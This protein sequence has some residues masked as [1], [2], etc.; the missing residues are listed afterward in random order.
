MNSINFSKPRYIILYLSIA[1]FC[2]PISYC[3][4]QNDFIYA[5]D[6]IDPNVQYIIINYSV[7]TNSSLCF[8]LNNDGI[9]DYCFWVVYNYYMNYDQSY[10]RMISLNNNSILIMDTIKKDPKKL[11]YYDIIGPNSLLERYKLSFFR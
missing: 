6:T 7:N 1:F 9:N 5:G 3:N 2:I 11:N 8:D 4:A 10:S